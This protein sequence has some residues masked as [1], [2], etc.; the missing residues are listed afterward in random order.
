[1]SS[2]SSRFEPESPEFEAQVLAVRPRPSL[3]RWLSACRLE[4]TAIIY[5]NSMSRVLLLNFQN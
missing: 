4:G 5:A 1:V 2:E 3:S